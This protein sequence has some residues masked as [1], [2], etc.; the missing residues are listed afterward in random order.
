MTT[1]FHSFTVALEKDI[2]EDD[3]ESLINAISM[4]KGV[5]S[6]VGNETGSDSCIAEMRA[7]AK[8]RQALY[9]L[10]ENL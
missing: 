5:L 6:V 9:D 2:R 8:F 10:A 3:A 1:R 4:M 7:K